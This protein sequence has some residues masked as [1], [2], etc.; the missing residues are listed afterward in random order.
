MYD[1]EAE[2]VTIGADPDTVTIDPDANAVTV[3]Y[4]Y[5]IVDAEQQTTCC[6]VGTGSCQT[7]VQ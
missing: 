7:I 1:L 6:I 5:V 2:M 3:K 4:E